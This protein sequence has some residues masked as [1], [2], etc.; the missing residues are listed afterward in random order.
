MNIVDSFKEILNRIIKE[1]EHNYLSPNTYIS[2]FPA[3]KLEERR[4]PCLDVAHHWP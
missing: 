1:F 4:Q 3:S 2:V